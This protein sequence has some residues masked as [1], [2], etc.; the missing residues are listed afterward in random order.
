MSLRM[1]YKSIIRPAMEY[2]EVL[3][4][5]CCDGE[6]ELL[7]SVQYEAGK[8]ITGAMSTRGTSRACLMAELGWEEMKVRHAIHKLVCYFK[9]VNNLNPSYL[10]GDFQSVLHTLKNLFTFFVLIHVRRH[11]M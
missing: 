6:S 2:A 1:L 7:E 5:G 4:D 8:V 3:W 10:K 9:I 11:K